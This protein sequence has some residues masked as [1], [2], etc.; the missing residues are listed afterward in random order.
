MKKVAYDKLVILVSDKLASGV[1]DD[2]RY[3]IDRCFELQ[4]FA[5]IKG[6][7]LNIPVELLIYEKMQIKEK[8]GI[9]E[10]YGMGK[11]VS[12]YRVIDFNGEDKNTQVMLIGTKF[13]AAA[14]R[15]PNIMVYFYS[16]NGRYRMSSCT[17]EIKLF[18]NS[19]AETS[20][21]AESI[22]LKP[23]YILHAASKYNIKLDV[24][25]KECVKVLKWLAC[26][27]EEYLKNLRDP[28][29]DMPALFIQKKLAEFEKKVV[30]LL[31]YCDFSKLK[32]ASYVNSINY[33]LV[34]CV[35]RTLGVLNGATTIVNNNLFST[36][37]S[38]ALLV[39]TANSHNGNKAIQLNKLKSDADKISVVEP[40]YTADW[41][42]LC[43]M[44]LT[45]LI[46]NLVQYQVIIKSDLLYQ[47]GYETSQP[48]WDNDYYNYTLF[49]A[50]RK[51]Y[52]KEYFAK[53]T[54]VIFY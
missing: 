41:F 27:E 52:D 30:E 14:Y 31:K 3:S 15:S 33:P 45:P 25:N 6:I 4:L 32:L 8:K 20:Y 19:E 37:I 43:S 53:F 9:V 12:D 17:K 11:D 35:L 21:K 7:E 46:H 23:L 50:P 40:T 1:V 36:L 29:P 10:V 34:M 42:R 26:N 51:A 54:H 13:S 28:S 47:I 39:S 44:K 18:F 16:S 24:S 5:A 2:I 48:Q 22:S 38:T 49:I